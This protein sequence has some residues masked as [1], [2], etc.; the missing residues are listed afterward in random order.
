MGNRKKWVIRGVDSVPKSVRREKEG[1]LTHGFIR[2][3]YRVL[4]ENSQHAVVHNYPH[5]S[6]A[7]SKIFVLR[8]SRI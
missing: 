6:L 1:K 5:K 7:L 4:E 2:D 8:L 3:G